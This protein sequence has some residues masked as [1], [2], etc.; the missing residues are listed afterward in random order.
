MS[1]LNAQ[2]DI[3]VKR[4]EDKDVPL[5]QVNKA[6]VLNYDKM[7]KL[8]Q[9]Y[10][11]L[12]MSVNIFLID[13]QNIFNNKQW[14]NHIGE[15]EFFYSIIHP[16]DFL[17]LKSAIQKN[18]QD[19]VN[20]FE[21]RILCQDH[22][23]QWYVLR[24][25]SFFMDEIQQ[26]VFITTAANIQNKKIGQVSLLE[27]LGAYENMLDVCVDCIKV[28]DTDGNVKHMNLSGR[29]AL[30]VPLD[31]KKFGMK[32]MDLLPIEVRGRG[33]KALIEAVKGQNARFA[34]KSVGAGITQYWDNIL[35][36]IVDENGQTQT[37]LCVSRDVT[38]QK[39]AENKLR[40][41]SELDDLTGLY[42]RKLFKNRLKRLI[43]DAKDKQQMAGILLID[44]DHFKH[45][46]D[47]LGHSAGDHLL[48]VLSKRLQLVSDDQGFV[49]RLGGDEFAI[50]VG[51]LKSEQ[52]F[53]K[54]AELASQQL[55]A[56][57]S[58]SGR[59]INGGMSIGCALYPRDA[60]DSAGL[61]QCVDT[62]LN[63]LKADGRG[64][65]RFYNEQMLINTEITAKQLNR[66]RNIIRMDMVTPYYQPKVDLIT[67]KIVGFE[68]LLRWES[69]ELG[70][71]MP[72]E[73]REAFKDYK[74]ASK[75]SELMHNKIFEQLAQCIENDL[76]VVPVALNVAPVEFLRDDYA[77]KL[78]Q[79]I[80]KYNIPYHLVE[81]EVTEQILEERGSDF[82]L[83]ALEILKRKG[84]RIALDDFGTGHSSL[85]RLR[86]YP[87]DCLKID[88]SFINLIAT[89]RTILAVIQ[90]ITELGPKLNLDIV[91]EGIETEE[92]LNILVESG[93][94][95]G[96]GYYF[97]QA[98][99][100]Q[101]MI[102][103]LRKF[104]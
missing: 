102:E 10:E 12:P 58:Y 34:G 84:V 14:K 61:I 24:I 91:A 69:P 66:A 55:D 68:A 13:G 27:Q 49:A 75:I 21:C 93:C 85:T 48:R 88:K 46:N 20:Q 77:E 63:D 1:I 97:S 59:L 56:P 5:G 62:A 96:Q 80:D 50:A 104:A 52:E 29:K 89:D 103:I 6:E 98:V 25:N 47:T 54:I 45:V 15:S 43:S 41:N 70:L 67:R 18:A 83:R 90:A 51:G 86:D 44:L 4:E 8:F 9:T 2:P 73:V 16:D 7:Q 38:L 28:L 57:I 76:N 23:Y 17:T 37:I 19:D 32:W 53:S 81:I 60:E 26:Q 100:L 40:E 36:P 71:Q 64:G 74:L 11:L 39:E 35:T 31:E 94:H 82:V 101:G 65:I 42:N 72:N 79:R 33:K 30:G 99:D 92:Q 22:G 3:M 78:L 87:V 95:I